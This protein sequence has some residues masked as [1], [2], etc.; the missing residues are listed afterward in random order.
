[1]LLVRRNEGR[2]EER[3]GGNKGNEQR[4]KEEKGLE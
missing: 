2:G 3:S 4:M 1:V